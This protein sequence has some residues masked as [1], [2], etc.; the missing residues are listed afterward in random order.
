MPQSR[1]T[2]QE[3]LGT[4]ENVSLPGGLRSFQRVRVISPGEYPGVAEIILQEAARTA[5]LS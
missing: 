1:N 5:Y 2:V 4:T 3:I